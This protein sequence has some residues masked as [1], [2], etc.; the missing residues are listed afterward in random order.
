MRS[1]AY[2]DTSCLVAIALGEPGGKEMAKRLTGFDV[3]VSS[4]LLEAELRSALA[5]NEVD[6]SPDSILSWMTWIFPDR[7]LG[8]E[9]GRVLDAGYLRGPDLWHLASALYVVEDPGELPFVTLDARQ[10]DVAGK[11]GF[12]E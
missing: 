12:P 4:N 10:R 3:L 1:A 6:A 7:P 8:R 2:V 11:L 5:R 9:I